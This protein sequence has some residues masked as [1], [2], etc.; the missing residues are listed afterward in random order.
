MLMSHFQYVMV[1]GLGC[2]Q[3]IGVIHFSRK[4]VLV[5]KIKILCYI[6]NLNWYKTFKQIIPCHGF[7]LPCKNNLG[8]KYTFHLRSFC[9]ILLY[10]AYTQWYVYIADTFVHSSVVCKQRS[11]TCGNYQVSVLFLLFS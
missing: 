9:I 11:F 1:S 8:S 10:N 3:T 7:Y 5:A 6:Q 4:N 2:K